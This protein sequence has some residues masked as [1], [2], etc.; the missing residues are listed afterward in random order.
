MNRFHKIKISLGL[1]F[2]LSP[3]CGYSDVLINVSATM[4]APACDIRS[5]NSSS[6]LEIG[7]NT[8]NTASLDSEPQIKNFSLY[9]SGCEFNRDLAIVMNPKGHK[10]IL[11]DGKNILSTSIEGLGIDFKEVTGG[12]VRELEMDKKQ[13]IYPER[14]DSSNYRVDLQAQLVS[15]IPLEELKPGRFS[16]SMTLSVTYN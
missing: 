4:I 13:R 15:A 10:S 5:E 14:L 16:S 9:I 2:L 11:H 8:V 6:P 7:F 1:F 3:I 12:A